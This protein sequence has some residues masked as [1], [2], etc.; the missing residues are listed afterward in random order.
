MNIKNAFGQFVPAKVEV[1]MN[2]NTANSNGNASNNGNAKI[3]VLQRNASVPLDIAMQSGFGKSNSASVQTSNKI[4]KKKTNQLK[5]NQSTFG[6]P[7]DDP[8]MDEEFDFEKNLALFNK[9][10]IWDKIDAN[11]KPDV[12]SNGFLHL[13]CYFVDGR[14]GYQALSDYMRHE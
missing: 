3:S 6:T 9:Q 8:V 5:K 14:P 10:A 2:A 11:L 13:F 4:D 1:K 12:V 7:V